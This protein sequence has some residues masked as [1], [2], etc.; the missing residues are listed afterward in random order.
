VT[1]ARHRK[2]QPRIGAQAAVTTAIAATALAG[3]SQIANASVL[4]SSVTAASATPLTSDPT[5][6]TGQA[7]DVCTTPSE[8][9]MSAWHADFSGI[10]IYLGW[11]N[12]G[13]PAGCS[14][15]NLTASW[16]AT[17]AADGWHF[18][19]IYVG[20]QPSALNYATDAAAFG[21][22]DAAAAV[23]KAQALGLPKGSVLY[24][25][26]DG[27]YS[28]AL[29]TPVWD[30][31]SAWTAELHSLGYRSGVY[32]SGNYT[33]TTMVDNYGSANTPDVLDIADWGHSSTGTQDTYVP[34][35][36]W[37]NAQRVIQYAGGADVTVGGYTLDI[38]QD[39]MGVGP[40]HTVQ[41]LAGGVAIETAVAISQSHWKTADDAT[42]PRA[43]AEAVV[44]TRSNYYADGLAGSPLAAA[45]KAPMLMTA[46]SGLNPE[47]GAEIERV[48]PPGGTVYLLGG[49]EALTPAVQNTLDDAGYHTVRIAGGTQYE[50]ALAIAQQITS[51][52]TR[53]FVATARNYYDALSAG[54]AAGSDGNTVI[55]LSDNDVLPADVEAYIKQNPQATVYGI[56][57]PGY[58]ALQAAHISAHQVVGGTAAGTAVAVAE[59]FYPGASTVGLATMTT[60]QDALTG[61]ALLA[62]ENSPILLTHSTGLDAATGQYLHGNSGSIA[63]LDVFGGPVAIPEGV[64]NQA[65]TALGGSG[66]VTVNQ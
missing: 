57:G 19:P 8:A 1:R 54:A 65:A 30:Y 18:I 12:P 63:D 40:L 41:R 32:G 2:P 53:I 49:V 55:V 7:F 50:T 66:E 42:D 13:T 58:A 11:G 52:P 45:L 62:T 48:L 22:A 21:K 3:T 29:N 15:A 44:L 5:D 39:Y 26:I 36:E 10:G 64:V 16:V 17:E 25:D 6:Y 33:I 46:P 60:Y 4:R 47:T 38:D 27:S 61:G 24:A 56:G 35:S 59:T 9:V 20:S 31:A 34:N 43:Q 14:S 51:S 37:A 28:S 23:A